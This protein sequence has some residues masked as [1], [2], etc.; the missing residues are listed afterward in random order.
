MLLRKTNHTQ[1]RIFKMSNVYDHIT[2][3]IIEQLENGVVPWVKPWDGDSA[4]GLPMNGHT[5]NAYSGI[6][7]LLGWMAAQNRG[8]TSNFW[9]TANQ[10][11]KEGVRIRKEEMKKATWMTMYRM[12]TFKQEKIDALAEN[13]TARETPMIKG[14][15]VYNID[16]LESVPE[17][18]QTKEPVEKREH[19]P[20]AACT[21]LIT[22][23]EVAITEM[24]NKAF[25][26]PSADTI[27]IP[28]IEKFQMIHSTGHESRL[29]RFPT[30]KAQEKMAYAKEELV[31]ELGAC[32]LATEQG[33][34]PTLNHTSYIASWVKCLK[35]NNKAIVQAASK[36]SKAVALITA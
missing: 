15:Q 1:Q 20:K 8:F 7:I 28:E 4:N 2:N 34:E 24:G 5:G 23:W 29:N 27:T 6:N 16:Q 22:N 13:R 17:K 9:M 3:Q 10:A 14:F 26:S 32:F 21:D 19:E 36:A 35:E 33:I 25:Y 31:A 18:F 30:N 12:I 11:R